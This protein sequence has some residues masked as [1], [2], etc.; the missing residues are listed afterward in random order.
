MNP[1]SFQVVI[2]V[3][4]SGDLR[5]A[6]DLTSRLDSLCEKISLA[7][8]RKGKPSPDVDVTGVMSAVVV[9]VLLTV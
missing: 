9:A 7:A 4:K 6:V 5:A 1:E 3:R 8:P 2:R